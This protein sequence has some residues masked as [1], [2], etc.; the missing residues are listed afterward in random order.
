MIDLLFLGIDAWLIYMG[1]KHQNYILLV[2][3]AVSL[4]ID[5][6]SAFQVL[7]TIRW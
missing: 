1:I 5:L 4:L 7:S 3:V 2:L 6:M